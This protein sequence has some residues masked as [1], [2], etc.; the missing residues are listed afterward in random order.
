METERSI[1]I[2]AVDDDSFMRKIIKVCL[3]EP[4]FQVVTCSDAM[5]AMAVFKKN[6]FDLLI[7]DIMMPGINGMELRSLIRHENQT[8]PIIMLTAKVDDAE[9]TLLKEI[10]S[11]KNTYYQSKGFSKDELVATVTGIISK[12]RASRMEKDYFAEMEKDI[13]LAG[14]IQKFMFPHWH[15]REGGA[16][17]CHYYHP[18]MEITGDVINTFKI[19]EGVFLEL[20]GDISGHGIQSA[21]CM[22]A[23]EISVSDF[24]R[25]TPQNRIEPHLLLTHL[26]SFLEDISTEHYMTCLVSVIDLNKN[27]ITYQTAGHP[28]FI[29]YSPSQEKFIQAETSEKGGIPL[30]LV[31]GT[32]YES[33]NNQ[34]LSLPEDAI[35]FAHTDGIEDIQND[36]GESAGPELLRE[37]ISSIAKNGLTPSTNF[38]I[39]DIFFKLG[40]STIKDDI[41]LSAI[42]RAIVEKDCHYYTI[43]PSVYAVDDFVQ[44]A[45]KLVYDYTK[46][47]TLSSKVEI[48]LSEFLNNVVIHGLGNRNAVRPVISVS[49]EFRKDDILVT[50]CD[51][52]KAWDMHP[53]TKINDQEADLQNS[54]LE[55]SGRGLALLKKIAFSVCRN[56]YADAL[57]ETTFTIAYK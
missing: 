12:V 27:T 48:L 9:G 36:Q 11:D 29:I 49:I 17:F 2:L 41:S 6:T 1:K 5:E 57:N 7:F 30:G 52:G 23:V 8:I 24:I 40:Y 50:V 22:A 31:A 37:F 10:S 33:Q 13:S 54:R 14:E 34:T 28:D 43:S 19:S 26:Q 3:P 18:Y 35:I 4:D 42:S 20:V 38:R 16:L 32:K 15:L 55:F 56:R 39:V 44:V 46:D 47:D 51:K 53:S 45:Y 25:K 21:L